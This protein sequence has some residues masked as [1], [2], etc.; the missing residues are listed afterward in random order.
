MVA[1][2]VK[3]LPAVMETWVQSLCQEDPLEKEMSNNSSIL[4][5]RIPCQKIPEGYRPWVARVRHD[6]ATKPQ[7]STNKMVVLTF[8]AVDI[9]FKECYLLYKKGIDTHS[10]SFFKLS[11]NVGYNVIKSESCSVMSNSLRRHGLHSSWNS[12]GQKA[13]PFSRGSS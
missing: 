2:L 9:D 6:L 13:V 1:Q 8:E 5:W 4:A 3:N 11:Q 7:I 12:L 10:I